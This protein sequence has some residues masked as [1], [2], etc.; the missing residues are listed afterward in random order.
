MKKLLGLLFVSLFAFTV[1]AHAQGSTPAKQAAK[2]ARWEGTVIRIGTAPSSLDVRE[3]NGKIDK[4]IFYDS[5]TAWTS[6]YHASDAANKIDPSEVKEGDRVIC[7]GTYNEKGEF[8][9]KTISKRL[10][11]SAH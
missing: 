8:H 1:V 3:V 6:Q 11:H 9:A 5:S 7:V 10:S 2:E 4:T